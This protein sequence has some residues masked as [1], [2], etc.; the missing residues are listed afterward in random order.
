MP[1][2]A[3]IGAV[4]PADPL[5]IF[6]PRAVRHHRARAV[7]LGLGAEFLFERTATDLAGRLG[8]IKR[9]FGVA[10]DIGCRSGL[11]ARALK[12][13]GSIDRLV[14]TDPSM[15]LARQAPRPAVVVDLEALPFRAR[16]FDL[17]LSALVLHWVNDL[18]GTLLQL[19]RMLR[20]GGL[21]L[22]TLFGGETLNALYAALI[23]AELVSAGGV[24]PRVSPFADLRDIGG[25][26]QRAGFVDCVVDADRTEVEYADVF[27]LMRDLRLMGE[28]NAQRERRKAVTRRDTLVRAAELY[29][30]RTADGR[31]I[32]GFQAINLTA[33]VPPD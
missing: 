8:E 27:G 9:R 16:S 10:V 17:V 23:E 2:A 33:W 19:R 30:E 7:R 28:T 26:L 3:M 32:A 20:P 12:G 22:A 14:S 5:R 18:P 13:R 29:R 4:S 1:A 6:D 25:L 31:I 11:M 21:L 15:A 24:S